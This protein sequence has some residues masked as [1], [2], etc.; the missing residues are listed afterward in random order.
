MDSLI[1]F[2]FLLGV[3]IIQHHTHALVRAETVKQAIVAATT[4]TAVT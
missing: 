4:A 2:D 3:F 1:N